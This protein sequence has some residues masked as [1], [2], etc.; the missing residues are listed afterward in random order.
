MSVIR[1][2]AVC[3]LLSVR[4]HKQHERVSLHWARLSHDKKI[5]IVPL[6]L[7]LLFFIMFFFFF[8]EQIAPLLNLRGNLSVGALEVAIIND[9]QFI[10]KRR[11]DHIIE[12]V[13]FIPKKIDNLRERLSN[14][15]LDVCSIDDQQKVIMRDGNLIEIFS[16]IVPIIEAETTTES[17]EQIASTNMSP[18]SSTSK[19]AKLSNFATNGTL[20]VYDSTRDEEQGKPVATKTMDKACVSCSD[21]GI[22]TNFE[23]L[24]KPKNIVKYIFY[25]ST[26]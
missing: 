26:I 12:I 19:Q 15:S 4:L 24:A 10:I 25:R 18:T 2:Y 14:A 7:L 16:D 22:Q 3:F 1:M 13:A 6:E 8:F 21:K 9:E 5:E 23:M 11:A 20:H 17:T